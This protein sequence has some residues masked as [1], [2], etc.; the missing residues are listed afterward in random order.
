[1]SLFCTHTIYSSSVELK[2][3]NMMKNSSNEPYLLIWYLTILHFMNLNMKQI[4]RTI[5]INN[6]LYC[7]WFYPFFTGQKYFRHKIYQQQYSTDTTTSQEQW[8]HQ[9]WYCVLMLHE[10]SP[11]VLMYILHYQVN[12]GM[13]WQAIRGKKPVMDLC[14]YKMYYKC[15]LLFVDVSGVLETFYTVPIVVMFLHYGVRR[16]WSYDHHPVY[17]NTLRKQL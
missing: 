2:S 9:C 3:V 14:I 16:S 7:S 15:M 4:R 6:Q 12:T 11:L 8:V 10:L 13:L 5:Q 1:M 17:I